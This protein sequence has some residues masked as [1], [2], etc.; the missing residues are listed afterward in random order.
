MRESS[1]LGD[2][3]GSDQRADWGVK[4][5]LVKRAHEDLLRRLALNDEGA[6]ESVLG[7][8]IGGTRET[9]RSALDAKA[10]ALVRLAGVIALESASAS[11]QWVVAAAVAAG[12][13]DDE[14]VGV[15]AALV[16]VVGLVRANSA[17]PELALAIGCDL[18]LPGMR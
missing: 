3:E 13:T 5:P 18:D 16:P 17:A 6:V 4:G 7:S 12:A 14:I 15:L 9:E 1:G 11:Y 10:H 8:T 2:A